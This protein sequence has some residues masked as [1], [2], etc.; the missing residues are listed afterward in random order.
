MDINRAIEIAKKLEPASGP[1]LEMDKKNLSPEELRQKLRALF[2]RYKKEAKILKAHPDKNYEQIKAI[3]DAN[4]AAHSQIVIQIS[5]FVNAVLGKNGDLE[6][7]AKSAARRIVLADPRIESHL[8]GKSVAEKTEISKKI[9]S[10][11]E[12]MLVEYFEKFTGRDLDK[13]MV[14]DELTT[15]TTAEIAGML[16]SEL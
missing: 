7:L 1:S 8:K 14:I 11:V 13:I 9:A 16:N 15:K 3:F 5:T 2:L 4:V 10:E 6:A 12:K